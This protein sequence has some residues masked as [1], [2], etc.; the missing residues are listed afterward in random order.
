MP[1]TAIAPGSR[2]EGEQIKYAS[3]WAGAWRR[4][5][6]NKLAIFGLIY[7]VV[8]F[9]V[10]VLAPVLTPYPY[11]K[12]NPQ[13]ALGTP[14]LLH[15]FGTDAIG[16]D[17]LSRIMF[18]ARAMLIVGLLVNIA[19]LVIGVPIGLIAGYAGGVLDWLVTRL[20]EMFSALPWYLIAL[21]LVMV[22]SPSLE[23]LI[24]ALTVTAWVGPARLVRGLSFSVRELD[25]VEA[26]HALGIPTW[27]VIALHILPQ[28]AP[29]LL[30]SFAA[31]IPTA[32]LAEAG[33]SFLGM[34]VRPPQ[35]SWGQMLAESGSY[36]Q[37]WPHMFI[38]PGM[39]ITL[40]VLAFQGM[41]DG[42]REAMDVNINV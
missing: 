29:L 40:T 7:V 41:A 42:L 15:P 34:G 11:D 24:I 39:M 17:M 35:P 33:M 8:I 21:F 20:I 5:R 14:S 4:F 27:R 30:W 9:L 3:F 13:Q 10:A 38:F 12:I 26:A 23:N 32:A 28:I 16:R 2:A 19:A 31:G 22:L 1:T 36:W 18:G 6:R 25:F 37:Y